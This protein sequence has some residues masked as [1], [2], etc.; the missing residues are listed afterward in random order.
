MSSILTVYSVPGQGHLL[1]V[2]KLAPVVSYAVTSLHVCCLEL[3]LIKPPPPVGAGGGY[4]F[5]GRPSVCAS[6]RP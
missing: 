4:M 3:S 6:V 5:S 1:A 2:N